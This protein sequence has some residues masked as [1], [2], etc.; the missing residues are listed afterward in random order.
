MGTTDLELIRRSF[1]PLAERLPWPK[2][3][4]ALGV[5]DGL[6]HEGVRAVYEAAGGE[7]GV[8]ALA[9][10]IIRIGKGEV[11]GRP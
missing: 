9:A 11:V 3:G 1:R 6:T 5:I 10:A 7:K 4:V 2:R 8:W